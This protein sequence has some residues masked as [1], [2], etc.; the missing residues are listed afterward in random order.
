[1]KHKIIG[2]TNC[3]DEHYPIRD[4]VSPSARQAIIEEIR[5]YGY[6]FGGDVHEELSPVFN[7]GTMASY[8]WRGWGDVM[9]EAWKMKNDSGYAYMNCYM[10][11]LIEASA[12]KYPA[13]DVDIDKI[14]P[15]EDI[16]ETFTIS[17]DNQQFDAIANGESKVKLELAYEIRKTLDVGDYIEFVKQDNTDEKIKVVVTAI[18]YHNVNSTQKGKETFEVKKFKNTFKSFLSVEEDQIVIAEKIKNNDFNETF[19]DYFYQY[20]YNKIYDGL[21][22]FTKNLIWGATTLTTEEIVSFKDVN[23]SI[24]ATIA[25][26]IGHEQELVEYQK[27]YLAQIYLNVEICLPKTDKPKQRIVFDSDIIEFLQLA[28]IKLACRY[29]YI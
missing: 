6:L 27:N 13:D 28:N 20:E 16:K 22:K 7:D 19:Y 10:D 17:L 9:A 26:F 24:R 21:E 5:K 18:P 15:L 8:S 25:N 12:R 29:Y 4:E 2:W 23:E 11:E 14:V 1:M 3:E